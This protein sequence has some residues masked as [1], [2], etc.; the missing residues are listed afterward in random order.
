MSGIAV[1]IVGTNQERAKNI[2]APLFD[3]DLFIVNIVEIPTNIQ[4]ELDPISARFMWALNNSR[5]KYPDLPVMIVSDL[6]SSTSDSVNIEDIV[7][8]TYQNGEYDLFYYAKWLDSCNKY[9]DRRPLGGNNSVM[10]VR[11][12][13]PHGLDAILFTE[14]ARDIILGLKDIKRNELFNI[15]T[16]SLEDAL[17]KSI[18]NG[19]LKAKTV[20]PSLFIRSTSTIKDNIEYLTT[21][22]C[23]VPSDQ[24]Q[25]LSGS[26]FYLWFGIVLFF[27]I[28]LSWA[29]LKIADQ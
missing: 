14:N 4:P 22:E 17:H 12:Y 13:S 15:A 27:I 26:S 20:T 6:V 18:V 5:S 28:L 8:N 24:N 1:Y 2:V 16:K 9:T 25:Q 19:N 21:A 29:A 3:R 10:E 23:L 11:T 7:G